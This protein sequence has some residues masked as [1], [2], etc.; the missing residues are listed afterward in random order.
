MQTK[1]SRT[2]GKNATAR[3][4]LAEATGLDS[5][6]GLSPQLSTVKQM[7]R[8]LRALNDTSVEQLELDRHWQMT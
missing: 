2:S 5:R 4:R 1:S 6:H 7:K 8:R 3:K